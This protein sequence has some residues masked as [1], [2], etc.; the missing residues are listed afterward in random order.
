MLVWWFVL[1]HDFQ[2]FQKL[3]LR[4]TEKK[5]IVLFRLQFSGTPPQGM[6]LRSLALLPLLL[7]AA[8]AWSPTQTLPFWPQYP[9]R[10]TTV[11]DGEWDFGFTSSISDVINF[12][13]K[14]AVT[15]N[16]TTVPSC[17]D[18]TPPGQL[19]PRGTAFYR[20]KINVTDGHTGLLYFAACAFY[21]QASFI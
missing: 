9:T 13:A 18:V 7:A 1:V 21:C 14:D 4:N 17:F 19:G 2:K 5:S 12:N 3:S 6:H 20:T 8:A 15:P 10:T 16:T 11:L